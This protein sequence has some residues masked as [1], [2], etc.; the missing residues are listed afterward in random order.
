MPDSPQSPSQT[1]AAI[2]P[3]RK[4]WWTRDH[5]LVVVLVVATAILLYLCWL[6]AKPF[7]GPIAWALALAIIARPVHCWMV[8]R[9]KKRPGLAAGLAVTVI[10]ILILAPA[11]FVGH[12]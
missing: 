3:D 8:R 5:A 11:I 4:G 12:Q 6:I 2:I 7:M 10:A 9:M 1:D